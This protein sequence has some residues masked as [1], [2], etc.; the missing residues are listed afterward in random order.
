MRI[1]RTFDGVKYNII[2]EGSDPLSF[3]LNTGK[4]SGGANGPSNRREKC[5]TPERRIRSRVYRMIEDLPLDDRQKAELKG[6]VAVVTVSNLH[7]IY[8]GHPAPPSLIL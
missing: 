1:S 3:D 6:Y 7:D 4:T 2:F 8:F 5:G